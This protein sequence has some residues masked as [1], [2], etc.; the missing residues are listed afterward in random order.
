MDTAFWGG[1]VTDGYIFCSNHYSLLNYYV[2]SFY[3][4]SIMDVKILL[5]A[6]FVSSR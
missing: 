6:N 1:K 4:C 2:R 5:K 3:S